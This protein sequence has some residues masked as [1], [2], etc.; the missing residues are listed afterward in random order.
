M[1]F[2]VYIV[3][4]ADETLYTGVAKDVARRLDEHN[5]VTPAGGRSRRGARYT[6][7][8]RPVALVYEAALASRS[9]ALR[10]EARLKS[11]SRAEKLA[12]IAA[13]TCA[14]VRPLAEQPQR[15]KHSGDTIRET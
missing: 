7:P 5:G 10:E 4:C 12:L 13:R 8:R 11:L 3:R 1:T 14:P 15:C 2:S 9:D 6:A